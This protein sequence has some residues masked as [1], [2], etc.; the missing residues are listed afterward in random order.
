MDQNNLR[1]TKILLP[2]YRPKSEIFHS[3]YPLDKLLQYGFRKGYSYD[4]KVNPL[5]DVE[6]NPDPAI[7]GFKTSQN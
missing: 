1:L 5:E 6:L 4:Q 3:V 7:Y 2:F